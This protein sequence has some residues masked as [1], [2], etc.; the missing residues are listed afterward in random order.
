MR[1][2]RDASAPSSQ[3]PSWAAPPWFPCAQAFKTE[4]EKCKQPRSQSSPGFG[5][6]G[7][8][9]R[10]KPLSARSLPGTAHLAV[11]PRL[12]WPLPLAPPSAARPNS[13]C[14]LLGSWQQRT[15]LGE[16][17]G[18]A[19]KFPMEF[20][21]ARSLDAVEG[22]TQRAPCLRSFLS[23]ASSLPRR[24]LPGAVGMPGAAVRFKP[25]GHARGHPTP[26]SPSQTWV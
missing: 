2:G 23:G 13:S 5:S 10:A 3:P 1:L 25:R 17:R 6:S 21:G 26:S 20:P 18:L 7:C 22:S 4:K 15:G 24:Q 14:S 8:P 16:P 19:G 11:L 12:A 9:L